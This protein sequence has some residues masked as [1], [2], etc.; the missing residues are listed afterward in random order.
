MPP[1]PACLES[2]TPRRQIAPCQV[3]QILPLGAMQGSSTAT[4]LRQPLA[5]NRT[6]GTAATAARTRRRCTRRKESPAHARIRAASLHPFGIVGSLIEKP[7]RQRAEKTGL[8][9]AFRCCRQAE[10]TRKEGARRVGICSHPAPVGTVLLT[11]RRPAFAPSLPSPNGRMTLPL[12][13]ALML[14]L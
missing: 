9:S 13:M 14:S 11:L 3:R 7:E 4:L 5:E 1:I 8:R 2:L 10:N 12:L 6:H